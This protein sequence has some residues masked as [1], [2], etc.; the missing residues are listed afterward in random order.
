MRRST[1]KKSCPTATLSTINPV[2]TYLESKLFF[3]VDK[4]DHLI[5]GMASW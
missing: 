5:H 2:W 1:S 4:P 3:R